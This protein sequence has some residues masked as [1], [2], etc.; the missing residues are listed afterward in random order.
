MQTPKKDNADPNVLLHQTMPRHLAWK[1]L[2]N[3]TDRFEV[4]KSP[5]N[6]LLK[7]G[8]RRSCFRIDFSK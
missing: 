5:L 8:L 3:I 6:L 4:L 7:G 1:P 2:R